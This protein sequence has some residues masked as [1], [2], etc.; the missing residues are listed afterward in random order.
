MLDIDKREKDK[1]CNHFNTSFITYGSRTS[2]QQLCLCSKLITGFKQGG[3][4][5]TFRIL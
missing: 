3:E 5:F 2:V 1:N 4:M